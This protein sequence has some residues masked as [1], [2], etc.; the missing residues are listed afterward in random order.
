MYSSR[1]HPLGYRVMIEQP[2]FVWGSVESYLTEA[3]AEALAA[4]L[5][6]RRTPLMYERQVAFAART[7]GDPAAF[8]LG[9]EHTL[10][11]IESLLVNGRY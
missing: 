7:W 1:E 5:N 2:G 8:Y 10:A 11:W 4:D 9:R 6:A 3:E